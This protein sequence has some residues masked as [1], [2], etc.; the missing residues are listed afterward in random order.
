MA[1]HILRQAQDEQERVG[2]GES[3][4]RVLDGVLVPGEP[5]HPTP[6]VK[7]NGDDIDACVLREFLGFMILP[8]RFDEAGEAIG[9][10]GSDRL[11][12]SAN[13]GRGAASN[14]DGHKRLVDDT[15]DIELPDAV[16]DVL[17]QGVKTLGFNMS[18]GKAL[19]V[20]PTP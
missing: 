10:G 7:D 4:A 16:A 15:N 6:P 2:I 8:V 17:S 20:Q 3:L 14:L 18:A 9:L 1:A 13:V 5:Q 19:G 12:R 11:L